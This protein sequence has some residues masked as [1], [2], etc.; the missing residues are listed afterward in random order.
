MYTQVL[1]VIVDVEVCER[2]KESGQIAA[3]MRKTNQK[4]VCVCVWRGGAG[5]GVGW[6]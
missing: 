6:V 1:R 2:E 4:E 5:G 3:N